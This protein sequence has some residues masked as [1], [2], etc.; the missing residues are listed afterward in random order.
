MYVS[1]CTDIRT[2]R[3]FF[4]NHK[5][6]RRRRKS[7]SHIPSSSKLQLWVFMTSDFGLQFFAAEEKW[8]VAMKQATNEEGFLCFKDFS[9]V[10][11]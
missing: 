4:L 9:H 5:R 7:G 10:S 6:K 11:Q 8:D 3:H 2:L 1:S